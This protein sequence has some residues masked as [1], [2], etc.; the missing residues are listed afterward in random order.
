MPQYKDLHQ[1]GMKNKKPRTKKMQELIDRERESYK[2]YPVCEFC[3]TTYNESKTEDCFQCQ[4]MREGRKHPT[5][6]TLRETIKESDLEWN[7]KT[8][9]RTVGLTERD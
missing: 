7:E 9:L 2:T 4:C 3:D 1:C 5:M 8:D 6:A